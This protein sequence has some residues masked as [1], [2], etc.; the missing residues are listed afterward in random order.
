MWDTKWAFCKYALHCS[1]IVVGFFRNESRLSKRMTLLSFSHPR[2][3]LDRSGTGPSPQPIT[4]EPWASFWCMI[5]PMR[6][7]SMLSKTGM[8]F[9]HSFSKV[10]C[11]SLCHA[12]WN[13]VESD[14][15]PV[16]RKTYAGETRQ[17]RHTTP[18]L[19]STR[20]IFCFLLPTA[21]VSGVFCYCNEIPKVWYLKESHLSHSVGGWKSKQY[22]A[23]SMRFPWLCH[24]MAGVHAGGR[25]CVK[26]QEARDNLVRGLCL[27]L[28]NN[29]LTRT[30]LYIRTPIHDLPRAP[31]V[32]GPASSH[33]HI[34]HPSPTP[35]PLFICCFQLRDWRFTFHNTCSWRPS[36]LPRNSFCVCVI[37]W[38]GALS[39]QCP[40]RLPAAVPCPDQLSRVPLV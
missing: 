40:H 4:V 31:P 21:T 12:L 20:L 7:L 1:L 11:V 18:A 2:I 38:L 14:I 3:Q 26:R 16:L 24:I 37:L 39:S 27:L 15:V 25:N 33:Q 10:T 6:S 23:G 35:E 5:S 19:V 28:C 29:L 34:G 36:L 22:G 30:N 8:R 13:L 17:G 32:Q 9:L